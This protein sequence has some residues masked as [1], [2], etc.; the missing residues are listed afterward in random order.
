M[1]ERVRPWPPPPKPHPARPKP[2][3]PSP[4][5]V[6]TEQAYRQPAAPSVEDRIA[7]V[8]SECESLRNTERFELRSLRTAFYILTASILIASGINMVGDVFLDDPRPVKLAM[9]GKQ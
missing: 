1:V 7:A 3:A 8:Q 2:S 6:Y 5:T 4:K 9:A